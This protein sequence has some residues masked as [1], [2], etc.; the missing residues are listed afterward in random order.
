MSVAKWRADDCEVLSRAGV[1]SRQ[2]VWP[3]NAPEA[4]STITQV[5]MEP[6]SVSA[7]HSH[8]SGEQIWIVVQ[9]EG[10][11]LLENGKTDVLRAGDI[12][13]TPAGDVHGITNGGN[14]PL[15]YFAI[16][17]PPQDF[18]YAYEPAKRG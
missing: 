14:E 4:Q 5:T 17:T 8:A 15:V 3:G 12:V 10:V 2:L 16:T 7:R 13:R 6:G 11:L 9:G 18:T 1:Q